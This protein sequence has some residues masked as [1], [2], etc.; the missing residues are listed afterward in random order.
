MGC[1]R[2]PES[3]K[4]KCFLKAVRKPRI[5][6]SEQIGK[7]R[8]DYENP[9]TTVLWTRFIDE[10]GKEA[11]LPRYAAVTSKGG[12]AR[13]HAIMCYSQAPIVVR[14]GIKFDIGL[15]GNF[16]GS[17]NIAFQQTT[18]IVEANG[19]GNPKKLYSRGFWADLARPPFIT[20]C[21]GR[22]LTREENDQIRDF[23]G[24]KGTSQKQF[25]QLIDYLKRP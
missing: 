3:G 17:P 10:A 2:Y 7:A 12:T 4:A 23:V 6:F 1:G 19:F 20:L 14:D 11:E 8:P 22:N 16:K 15:F 24:S 13:H 18:P 25:K 21:G 5:L 9:E